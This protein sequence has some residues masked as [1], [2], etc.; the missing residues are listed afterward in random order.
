MPNQTTNNPFDPMNQIKPVT[1]ASILQLN[2]RKNPLTG[3][4]GY[5]S[6]KTPQ[7]PGFTYPGTTPSYA[8]K[9]MQN[10]QVP[11]APSAGAPMVQ[12]VP[13][14]QAQPPVVSSATM[15]L[16]DEAARNNS[17]TPEQQAKIDAAKAQTPA[18][19]YNGTYDVPTDSG[20]SDAD[21]A[22]LDILKAQMAE[23]SQAEIQRQTMAR[24]QA[25]V[26]ALDKLYA[27]KK[28]EAAI[29]GSGLLGSSSA[30][31]ARRGLIGSDFGAAQTGKVEKYN[32]SVQDALDAEKGAKIGAILSKA[33]EDAAAEF[34]A[35]TA[36][37]KAGAKEYISFLAGAADKK[38]E[39][40]TSYVSELLNAGVAEPGDFS[41]LA[42]QL[43]ATTQ[44]VM[45]EY[46]KQKAAMQPAEKANT[47]VAPGSSIFD[48]KGNLVATAPERPVDNKPV[49]Q[50]VGGNLLQWNPQTGG[51][52]TIFTAPETSNQKIVKVNGIDYVQNA[53]GSLSTP[54]VPQGSSEASSL[55]SQALTSAKEL[56][57]K[58]LNGQGTSA[59]GKSA[60][61]Q[62]QNIP[63]TEPYN[64][65]VQMNNLKSLLSLDNVKLLKGQGA[66]SDAERRLLEQASSKLDAGLTEDQFKA[67]LQDLITG[68]SGAG[69]QV[70]SSQQLPD[71]DVLDFMAERGVDRATAEASLNAAMQSGTY[72]PSFSKPLSMGGNGSAQQIAAAIKKV[73]SNGNY[74]AKGASGENGAYQF[75]PATWAGWAKQ[76]LGNANAP[77]TPANQDKVANA[78]IQ[79]L[80]DQGYNAQQIALIWN[81]G[82]PVVKKGVNS[83]G[84]AYDSGSYANKVLNALG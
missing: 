7:P 69:S 35:K 83:K 59:I 8:P 36:A 75:M 46:N 52:N 20:A 39:K 18:S 16:Q 64:F 76:Y 78:K 23:P 5:S 56:M 4:G 77:M 55:K 34:E 49:T 80:L 65:K 84:V 67:T 24:F 29:A 63:G 25:E 60:I 11:M 70:Q 9:N 54:N 21:Q 1:Q 43:G 44:S 66:V 22:Y 68:L 57:Q 41:E 17:L 79:S 33:N 13:V 74:N 3:S 53:D 30:I 19:L 45:A 58:L 2:Q 26:D 81:G 10:G 15:Q 12:P 14:A 38:K 40:V 6:A 61:L 37:R 82:T 71:Q 73:E 48:S 27:E 28:S 50:S 42:K 72:Q 51:W 32:Q 62:F 31:Q 47:V